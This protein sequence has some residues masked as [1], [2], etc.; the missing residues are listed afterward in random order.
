MF[1]VE[2]HA[3][4]TPGRSRQGINP[5]NDV[6]A[7]QNKQTVYVPNENNGNP[8]REAKHQQELLK[9]YFS[10]VRALAGQEDSI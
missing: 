4:D 6:V 2:Q 7:L 9:D 3:E 8:S 5:E 10:H 1:G